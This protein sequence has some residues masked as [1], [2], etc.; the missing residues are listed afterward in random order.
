[1]NPYTETATFKYIAPTIKELNKYVD[2]AKELSA[3]DGYEY[4]IVY[5]NAYGSGF[6]RKN[7]IP[8]R[9]MAKVDILKLNP[10]KATIQ[11]V[12]VVP[13]LAPKMIPT[14]WVRLKSPAFTKETTITVV[15]PED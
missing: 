8:K 7:P 13:I 15:A 14:D 9:G 6:L 2:K 10:K 1:M 3:M 4:N 12:M 11:A 5:T